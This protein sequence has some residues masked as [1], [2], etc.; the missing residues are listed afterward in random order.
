MSLEEFLT[1]GHENINLRIAAAYKLLEWAKA[2]APKKKAEKY[3][4]IQKEVD[5]LVEKYEV[6]GTEMFGAECDLDGQQPL[7]DDEELMEL[8][9][10]LVAHEDGWEL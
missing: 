1:S 9:D 8:A 6:T 5:A 3:E 2:G 4:E 10:K 7:L